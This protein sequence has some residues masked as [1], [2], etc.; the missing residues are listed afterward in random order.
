M[1]KVAGLS[2]GTVSL[3]KLFDNLATTGE[4]NPKDVAQTAGA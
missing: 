2:A 1:A 3:D 4:A